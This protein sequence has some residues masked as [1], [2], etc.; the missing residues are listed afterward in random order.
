MHQAAGSNSSAEGVL[1]MRTAHEY[2]PEFFRIRARV[3][4]EQLELF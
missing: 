4:Y 1:R 3:F 2:E